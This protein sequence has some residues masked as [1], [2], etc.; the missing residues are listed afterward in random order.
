MNWLE[1]ISVK[2]EDIHEAR[3]DGKLLFR[4]SDAEC[5]HW[6]HQHTSQSV[7]YA[8]KYDGYTIT[9]AGSDW[10]EKYQW[11]GGEENQK[12][13]TLWRCPECGFEDRWSNKDLVTR[14]QPVCPI[15]DID[16]E[17]RKF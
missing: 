2:Y 12:E 10:R 1:K 7:D 4:G 16:M 5:W 13:G 14:G 6:I 11:F 15:C 3:K 9:P 17:V 8:M